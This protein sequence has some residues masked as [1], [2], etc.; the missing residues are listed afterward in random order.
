[1]TATL[2]LPEGAAW[3]PLSAERGSS[4]EEDGVEGDLGVRPCIWPQNWWGQGS[5]G[6]T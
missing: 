6:L 4:G 3:G 2:P 5:K 1:M